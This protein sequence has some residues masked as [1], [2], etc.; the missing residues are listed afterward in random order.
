[1]K[2]FFKLALLSL[3]LLMV[4]LMSAL[5]AMRFA[6]HGRE[7]EVQSFVGL[8][9]A[10][11]ERSA[12]SNG[13]VLQVERQY[14][15]AEIPEGKILSQVPA[16]GTKVRR[17]YQ[18]RAAQSL[19]PQRVS[20]PDVTGQ[21]ARAAQL[22]IERRGLDIGATATLHFANEP[23]G[24][25]LAQS[26]PPNASGISAPRISL[27][28]TAEPDPPAFVVPNFV[29]QSLGNVTRVLQGSGMRVGTVTVAGFE[30]VQAAPPDAAALQQPVAPVA[31]S[32]ASLI[33]SQ[34]PVPGQ[35]VTLGAAVN[36]E[37]SR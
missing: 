33:L 21:T 36:F 25:V 29:G 13:L 5:T 24:E 27:L 23:S 17:G 6:I 14:Y 30:P 15:S 3:I 11:A 10:E 4:A 35:K 2:S 32:P 8:T 34:T 19:G 9:V 7:V 20:I 12:L 22:N 1:M 37:V 18:I 28:L 31:A 26:P 16:A